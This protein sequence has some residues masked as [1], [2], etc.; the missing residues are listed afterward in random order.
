MFVTPR[1]LAEKVGHIEE[2]VEEIDLISFSFGIV[3]GILLG[4]VMLKFG[5]ISI[6]LGSAGGL[7]I[8]GI[9]IGFFSS[10]RPTF[11]RV[12]AAARYILMEMGLML[13]MTSV[14]LK[15]GAGIWEALMEHGLVIIGCGVLVTLLPALI[16]YAFGHYILKLNP[17]LLLG[18]LTGAMTST[19]SL[20]VV[21]S[22][23]KS[24]IPALGYAGTYT[25]ANV[26]LTFAG[27]IIMML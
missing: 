5:N 26:F 10:I 9:L 23:A 4:M 1:K 2:E 13:F 8:M 22:A 18:S 3:F 19:P 15:A 25:F 24:S 21:T 7:L 27:T 14:G 20:N 16:G 11:G 6:G 17:V 12:P